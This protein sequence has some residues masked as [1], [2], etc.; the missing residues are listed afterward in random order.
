MVLYKAGIAASRKRHEAPRS[1][2]QEAHKAKGSPATKELKGSV[3]FMRQYICIYTYI[4]KRE[5]VTYIY[6][7]IHIRQGVCVYVHIHMYIYIYIQVNMCI[8][9]YRER[10][11]DNGPIRK[12]RKLKVLP[13][14]HFEPS[15]K[16]GWKLIQSGQRLSLQWA[17]AQPA[18][19]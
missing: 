13:N 4:S 1:P 6:I 11:F 3:V 8:Y 16:E 10:G 12:P 14:G 19:R 5:Y 7:Y 18:L 2:A 9:V 15:S 17:K